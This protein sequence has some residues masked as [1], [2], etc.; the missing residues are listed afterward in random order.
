MTIQNS[1]LRGSPLDSRSA[2][3]RVGLVLVHGVG[4]QRRFQHLDSQLRDLIRAFRG[5]QDNGRIQSVSVDIAG[6]NAAAFQAEQDTWNAGSEPSVNVVIH[7]TLNGMPQEAH[8]LVH[9]V[10]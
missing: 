9:E 4:E 5:L 10:W 6:G 7:H 3:E 1:E 2:V 8:L